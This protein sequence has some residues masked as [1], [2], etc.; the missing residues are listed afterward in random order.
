MA[1]EKAGE[2]SKQWGKT[3]TSKTAQ[4]GNCW[5]CSIEERNHD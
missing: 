2:E 3:R 4:L 5:L 1:E